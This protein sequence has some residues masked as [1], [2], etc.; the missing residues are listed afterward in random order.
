MDSVEFAEWLQYWELTAELSGLVER[1]PTPDELG[2]RLAAAFALHNAK[3]A[4]AGKV[5][6][7]RR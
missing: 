7:E 4:A 1:D 6:R 3:Q 5:T 2:D